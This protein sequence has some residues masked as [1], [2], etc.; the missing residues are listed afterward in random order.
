MLRRVADP[1]IPEELLTARLLLRR[2]RPSDLDA[3]AEVFAQREV[4]EFPFGRGVTRD[5]TELEPR[6][7]KV[8]EVC[9]VERGR[10]EELIRSKTAN[11]G[12]PPELSD[13]LEHEDPNQ[14]MCPNDFAQGSG[15]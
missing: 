8:L 2:W 7:N 1:R 15:V 11:C 13:R 14:L 5:E 3:L 6:F 4:W 9:V 10:F 12:P